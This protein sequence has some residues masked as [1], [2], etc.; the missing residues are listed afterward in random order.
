MKI[1]ISGII[2][3]V[4]LSG[5]SSKYSAIKNELKFD[6]G[7]YVL[8]P[9]LV[10]DRSKLFNTNHFKL[11]VIW[12]PSLGDKVILIADLGTS[13]FYKTGDIKELKLVM[14]EKTI[15]G[16]ELPVSSIHEFN[17]GVNLNL[18]IVINSHIYRG[19]Y[20]KTN[21]L[22]KALENNSLNSIK[23]VTTEGVK[24]GD[25]DY[26]GYGSAR[27]NVEKFLEYYYKNKS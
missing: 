19:F 5:C 2:F 18:D 16:E 24:T 8:S 13:V 6:N 25:L 17:W 10:L 3:F 20:F 1:I 26:N 9:G 4:L 12:H 14:N 21:E 23:L 27:V 15:N 11:G 22:K 7:A